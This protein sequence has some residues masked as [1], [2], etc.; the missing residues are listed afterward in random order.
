MQHAIVWVMTINEANA[1]LVTVPGKRGELG[2][3]V[4][5]GFCTDGQLRKALAYAYRIAGNT[6]SANWH[7]KTVAVCAARG[8]L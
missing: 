6:G 5:A 7:L 8:V 1:T 4:Q 2:T 3:L